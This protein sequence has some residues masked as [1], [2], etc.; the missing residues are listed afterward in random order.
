MPDRKCLLCGDIVGAMASSSKCRSCKEKIKSIKKQEDRSRLIQEAKAAGKILLHSCIAN[1][2][3]PAPPSCLCRRWVSV[4]EAQKFVNE[5]RC[6]DLV[7]RKPF[8][9]GNAVVEASK[10]KKSPRGAGIETAHIFRGLQNFEHDREKTQ[11]QRMADY[12]DLQRRVLEDRLEKGE[13]ERHRWNVWNELALK[14]RKSITREIPAEEWRDLER[15]Y[16]DVPL[17]S[18]SFIDQR[19][20]GGVG[21]NVGSTTEFRGI[22]NGDHC[23]PSPEDEPIIQSEENDAE[24][25]ENDN[26]DSDSAED[27]AG[28]VYAGCK[29]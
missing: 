4:G 22:N 18:M 28:T 10:L 20:Q 17:F 5:G 19:T 6:V 9:S 3:D 2:L 26:C 8:F 27:R 16:L 21:V 25:Y 29:E 14:F 1:I 12:H 15:K 23:Q 24:A 7:T 11:E 13:D